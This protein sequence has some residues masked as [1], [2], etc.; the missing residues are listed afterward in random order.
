MTLNKGEYILRELGSLKNMKVVCLTLDVEQ[1]YGARLAE[2]RY[3]GLEHIPDL[4]N[5]FKE[6]DIPLT[7]FVQGS[8]L[9]SHPAQ[10]DQLSSVD[11]EFELHSYSHPDPQRNNIRFEIE[12]GKE[13]YRKFF[14]KDPMGYRAPLGVINDGDYQVLA[15]H[16]FKFDSSIFPSIRPGVFN[17]MRKPI[18]PYLLGNTGIIEFPITVLSNLI[19]L[20][21]SLSYLKLLGKPFLRLIRSC[22]LPSFIVFSFHLHDLITLGS[23]SK[24][25][26]E[27][28]SPPYRAIYN[29]I[30]KGNNNGIELLGNLITIFSEKG[31]RFLNLI[32]VYESIAGGNIA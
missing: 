10:I 8:L 4:V 17:N 15:W 3:E 9:E 2:P 29:R 1:D 20:P 11:V 30:Y 6:W 24:I 26:V 5:F 16:G 21:M 18:K 7:C 31:Y 32:D 19:R 12:K 28:F 23:S 25:P 13:A 27:K 14:G 22:R